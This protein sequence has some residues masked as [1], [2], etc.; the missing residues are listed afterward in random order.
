M[1]IF[2]PSY[3]HRGNFFVTTITFQLFVYCRGYVHSSPSCK[4]QLTSPCY[5]FFLRYPWTRISTCT[6][7]SPSLCV[8][9]LPRTGEGV[10]LETLFLIL[11]RCP[12][13]PTTSVN[14]DV[15]FP[16][17]SPPPLHLPLS[18]QWRRCAVLSFPPNPMLVLYHCW[19]GSVVW[20]PIFL[21]LLFSLAPSLVV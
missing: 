14:V 5:N 8:Q 1:P 19:R 11:L 21:F 3:L 12:L 7:C 6:Q 16:P 10:L 20:G 2:S 15:L 13:W 4:P 9:F 18:P 17:L